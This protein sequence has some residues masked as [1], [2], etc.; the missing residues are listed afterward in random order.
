MLQVGALGALWRIG[1]RAIRSYLSVVQLTNVL[2]ERFAP[3]PHWYL[4]Q[5]GVEP[6]F[7]GQGIGQRLLAPTL[8]RIDQEQMAVY[9]E[10]LNPKALPFYNKL[11]FKVC[12]EV[13]LPEGGPLMWSM[14]REPQM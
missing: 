13:N 14:R 11:G 4:S 6:K 5:L 10:T 8:E 1:P 2:H 9:L 7:Q 12:E 3:E